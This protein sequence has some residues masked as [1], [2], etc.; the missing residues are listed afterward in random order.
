MRKTASRSARRPAPASS[1]GTSR[2]PGRVVVRSEPCPSSH[3]DEGHTFDAVR[4]IGSGAQF[5]SRTDRQAGGSGVGE[6]SEAVE[7][8]GGRPGSRGFRG[9]AAAA[10]AV[11]NCSGVSMTTAL[12]KEATPRCP[13]ILGMKR[14]LPCFVYSQ[15]RA[16]TRHNN[17]G[18][19]GDTARP[20]AGWPRGR[21][22]PAG[23]PARARAG[24]SASTATTPRRTLRGVRACGRRR[25]R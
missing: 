3:G 6:R 12:C 19:T 11:I 18:I 15:R 13:R 21:S 24:G 16:Q 10:A 17:P 5:L 25:P 22:A 1:L 14:P 8:A 2:C 9:A 7:S 4:R 23:P 20:C